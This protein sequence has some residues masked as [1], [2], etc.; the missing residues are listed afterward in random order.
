MRRGLC[1]TMMPMQTPPLIDPVYYEAAPPAWVASLQAFRQQH[2]L[3]YFAWQDADWT[4]YD[5]GEG[6]AI[7][8]VP[9]SGGDA[10][11]Y[12]RY[13]IGLSAY[14]RVIA[15]NIPA[16]VQR[17]DVAAIGLQGL[18]EYLALP[19]VHVIGMSFGGML[20]QVF[21]RR[22]PTSVHHIILAQTTV[23]AEHIA[24]RIRMQQG[25]L[26]LYPDFV[27][28][29]LMTRSVTRALRQAPDPAPREE[30]E[31]WAA[32]YT[33]M[34]ARRFRRRELLARAALSLSFHTQTN[35]RGSDMQG[36][37]GRMLLIQADQDEVISEGERGA[38]LGMYPSAYMQ[39]LENSSHLAP[40]LQSEAL[41]ASMG[42]F[43]LPEELDDDAETA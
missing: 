30:R 31:F 21:M 5:I 40:I 39:E 8:L 9:G 32:C 2:S 13:F 43:L 7:L 25:F 14:F 22:F 42:R 24:A 37:R 19:R 34:Y 23:P 20:A 41:I 27:Q 3:R 26:R 29:P 18:L 35:F 17:I 28:R 38:L 1:A 4:Y 16:S 36:W 12:F 6:P 11:L 10:E 15:P 33:E